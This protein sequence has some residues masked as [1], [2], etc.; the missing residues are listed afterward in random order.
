MITKASA[1]WIP[2]RIDMTEKE[3]LIWALKTIKRYNGLRNDMDA[4][5]YEVAEYALGFIEKPNPE[6]FGLPDSE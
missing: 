5:L 3:K 6:D 1:T 2:K 4:Y